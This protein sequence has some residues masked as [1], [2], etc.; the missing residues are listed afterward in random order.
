MGKFKVTNGGFRFVSVDHQS[1]V[2]VYNPP[3]T[4]IGEREPEMD[5]VKREG[6][7]RPPRCG[8]AHLRSDSDT[9][10]HKVEPSTKGPNND[11]ET[12]CSLLP[13]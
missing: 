9:T 10:R 5:R 7:R 3:G 4:E 8:P 12:S 2:L 6:V 1:G 11:M 13:V